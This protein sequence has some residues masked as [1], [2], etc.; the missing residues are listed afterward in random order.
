[1]ASKTE[2]YETS[3]DSDTIGDLS[4]RLQ[5]DLRK[6]VHSLGSYRPFSDRWLKMAGALF[7]I[8]NITKMEVSLPKESK[9]ATLWDCDELALRFLLEDGKLNLVLRNLIAYKTLERDMLVQGKS[10]KDEFKTAAR[11]FE[12]GS[13]VTLKH[14]W[15][16]IEALQTT[17][18]P[19]MVEFIASVLH[20]VVENPGRMQGGNMLAT[21]T[22]SEDLQEKICPHYI[23]ALMKGLDAIEEDR[24]MPSVR[25]FGLVPTFVRFLRAHHAALSQDTLKASCEALS[26]LFDT[27]DYQTNEDRYITDDAVGDALA[28]LGDLFIQELASGDSDLRRRIRPLLDELMN[29]K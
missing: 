29:H 28:E 25:R 3:Q 18:L 9:E 26:I 23:L 1:M 5:D 27:D 7:R 15:L 16:H 22:N 8:G 4:K 12:C 14:A 10:P 24:V 13:G 6:A 11:Q 17:D 20:A 2:K 19:M 21:D